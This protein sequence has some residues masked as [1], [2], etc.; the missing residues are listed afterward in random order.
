M[1]SSA[2]NGEVITM[3]VVSQQPGRTGF[4]STPATAEG[5]WAAAFALLTFTL[6]GFGEVARRAEVLGPFFPLAFSTALL[7]GFAAVLAVRRG[8]RSLLA[9]VAF[10][11]P[12]VGV[13]FGIGE[14]LG[15]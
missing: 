4:W 15:S 3:R 8:E 6:A 7:G 1:A 12:L 2:Q 14:V 10:V 5:S 11:P 13:A 9:M